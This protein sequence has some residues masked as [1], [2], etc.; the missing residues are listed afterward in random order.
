MTT[1]N[2]PGKSDEGKVKKL[3]EEIEK[4]TGKSPE[5]LY[6]EREKRLRDAIELK[7]PDRVPVVLTT[8]YFP[9]R[10]VGGLTVADSYYK[11]D[12]WREATRKT[13]IELEPDIQAAQAGGSGAAL[14]LLEP[15]LFK[16]AGDGLGLDA[17]HQFIE[18]EPLKAD[19]YD[20]FLS[21]PGDFTLRYYLPRVWKTL[22]AFAKLPPLQSLW[23]PS[24]MAS[25]SSA[26]ATP[27]VVKAFETLFKAGQEQQ[28]YFQ[29]T[30]NLDE[31]M[32]ILGFPPLSHGMAAAPFDAISDYLR[33]MAGTMIDMYR[34]P[35]KLLKACEMILP[36]S[37]ASGTATIRSKRGNPKR[38]SSALHRGSDGFMS[39]K[40]FETFYWPTLKKLMLATTDMGLVHVPFYEG[41]WAQRLEYLLELPKKKTIARFALTDLVKAKEV[42]GG[43]T[44]IMGGVPHTLMQ[45]GSPQQVE[46]YCKNLIKTVGKGGGF[47]LTTSTGLT[48]EAKPENVR[49]MIESA[50]KYGRY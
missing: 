6:E 2:T 15:K 50:K 30:R 23:G 25:F 38:V 22:E 28:K 44:C 26:F 32:A 7:E 8:N 17:M 49:A 3:R 4:K 35:D 33:G 31:E 12:A 29:A 9:L 36:R 11:H 37:I 43:H 19:E 16:W 40:H 10:Y 41:D 27:E 13:I 34:N 47:I 21:D 14:G 39:L 48:H 18:G 24:T 1:R 46:E 42:L 5:E 20:L 45:T